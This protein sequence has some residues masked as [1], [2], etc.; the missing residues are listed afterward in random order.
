MSA[1]RRRRRC[2]SRA[3]SWV[4]RRQ[5]RRQQVCA[6]QATREEC[7]HNGRKLA[8][9]RLCTVT[10]CA[11]TRPAANS[12]HM[13]A[14]GAGRLEHDRKAVSHQQSAAVT[15]R[16]RSVYDQQVSRANTTNAHHR[17]RTTAARRVWLVTRGE[18]TAPQA[19]TASTLHTHTHRPDYG[20]TPSNMG[21]RSCGNWREVTP[22]DVA[23]HHHHYT[24]GRKR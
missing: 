24:P 11:K 13:L 16:R 21:L 8:K 20:D 18:S 9:T 22:N 12:P 15:F 5:G 19:Q 14:H 17:S 4:S 7:T 2:H 1:S 3:R 10:T 23:M 6:R